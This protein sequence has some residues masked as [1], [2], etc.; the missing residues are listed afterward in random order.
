MPRRA[1]VSRYRY[2]RYEYVPRWSDLQRLIFVP[3]IRDVQR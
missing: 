3:W 2:L 1:D